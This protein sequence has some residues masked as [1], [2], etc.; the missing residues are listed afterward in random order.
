MRSLHAILLLVAALAPALPAAAAE[1]D[2]AGATAAGDADDNYVRV[3]LEPPGPTP[4]S[5]IRY[6]IT[7]RQPATTAVHRRSLPGEEEAL[8]ALG[9]LT[10]SEAEAVRRL[11]ADTGAMTLP[12][13]PAPPHAPAT[14]L[15]WRV[16]LLV[17]GERHTFLVAAPEAQPDRRY[18]RL[19]DGVR[20]TVVRVA[21]DLPFRNVF[22]APSRKGWL[23]VASVPSG[24][25]FVDDFDTQ[26]DTP[27]YAY[28]VSSGAHQIRVKSAD[29]RYDRTYEVRVE[30]GGTTNLRVDLR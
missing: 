4:F 26:L 28:E 9:L 18:E 14:A 1:P 30:P 3:T 11:V 15:T 16:E 19:I 17:A 22:Y 27:V 7:A 21:G 6:E 12:D 29:G 24:R 2:A 23:N 10:A 13:A 8:H 5:M 25:L 20:R